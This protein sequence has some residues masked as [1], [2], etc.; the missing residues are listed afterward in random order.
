MAIPG[1]RT[2]AA[3]G[4]LQ[5]KMAGATDPNQQ[6]RIQRR[7]NYLQNNQGNVQSGQVGARNMARP[8]PMAPQTPM[9]QPP[10]TGGGLTGQ[11]LAGVMDGMGTATPQPGRGNS[12][13]Y[14]MTRNPSYGSNVMP[15]Y[16]SPMQGQMTPLMPNQTA[17]G[18][19]TAMP[20]GGYRPQTS[21]GLTLGPQLK[22]G[23]YGY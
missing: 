11:D 10:Q 23:Q 16:M 15:N 6:N 9:A 8:G 3:V 4:N 12:P 19:V 18:T 20:R 7:I 21:T 13:Y 22:A 5:N 17:P 14:D 1:M 2:G